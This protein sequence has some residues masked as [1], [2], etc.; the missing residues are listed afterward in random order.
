MRCALFLYVIWEQTEGTYINVSYIVTTS[1]RFLQL[2]F[3]YALEI[4]IITVNNGCPNKWWKKISF[5]RL[6]PRVKY[7]WK[8]VMFNAILNS[9][10][11]NG[12][13]HFVMVG[14]D[15]SGTD[16]FVTCTTLSIILLYKSKN[17]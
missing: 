2:E 4:L 7:M 15:S 5:N 1:V 17:S 16:T 14:I 8:K 13:M 10:F 12:L 9:I 3:S 11:F 6:Q